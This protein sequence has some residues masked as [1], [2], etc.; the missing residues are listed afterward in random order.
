MSGSVESDERSAEVMAEV[1]RLAMLS[2]NPLLKAL[3]KD[4]EIEVDTV[5]QK[6]AEQSGWTR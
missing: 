3:P 6:I 1:Y 4:R 5:A 2:T